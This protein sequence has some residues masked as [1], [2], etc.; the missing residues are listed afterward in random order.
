LVSST[1]AIK[2]RRSQLRF[3]LRIASRRVPTGSQLAPAGRFICVSMILMTHN[4]YHATPTMRRCL[5][6]TYPSSCSTR[7]STPVE[8]NSHCFQ[9]LHMRRFDS[10]SPQGTCWVQLFVNRFK[11]K[12]H[13]GTFLPSRYC[14]GV[15]QEG[16]SSAARWLM[17]RQKTVVR[18]L[19]WWL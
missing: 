10:R 5:S 19:H 7:G 15:S 9:Q 18:M 2:T 11:A 12:F 8:P 1:P 17:L 6:P 16:T 4:P 13:D 3:I 14:I